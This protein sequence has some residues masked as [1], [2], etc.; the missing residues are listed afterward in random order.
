MKLPQFHFLD[1]Q[2]DLLQI[3][4]SKL[5]LTRN[6]EMLRYGSEMKWTQISGN[7]WSK[8]PRDVVLSSRD[9]K[10]KSQKKRTTHFTQWDKANK[11]TAVWFKD[12]WKP[13]STGSKTFLTSSIWKSS[14]SKS[15]Q[16]KRSISKEKATLLFKTWSGS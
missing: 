14:K 5:R 6:S 4:L 12:G 16:V 15:L 13:K 7:S 3:Y 8:N 1:K 10:F 9:K 11:L 2:S